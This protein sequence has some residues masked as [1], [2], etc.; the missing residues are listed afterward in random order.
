M[1]KGPKGRKRAGSR[2]PA[3]PT[4]EAS[5]G[6][7]STAVPSKAKKRERSRGPPGAEEEN[8]KLR[9]PASR[10]A[11][12]EKA[13]AEGER[14]LQEEFEDPFGDEFESEDCYEDDGEGEEEEDDVDME[15]G[16]K[17]VFRPGIDHL[18]DGEQLDVDMSSYDM[19]HRAQVDWPCLSFD[20]MPDT[21]GMNRNTYPMTCYVIAG[22]QADETENNRLY[23]MKWSQLYRTNKDDDS[24]S[25]EDSDEDEDEDAVMDFKAIP[26]PGGVN[27]VRVMP[28][29]RHLSATWSDTGKVHMWN[30]LGQC[31]GLDDPRKIPAVATPKPIFTCEKH[32]TEGFA[33]DWNPHTTG[34]FLS[35]SCD[36]T[37][38]LW[39]P[40]EGGWSVGA[41]KFSAHT[42]SVE[43]VQWKR[44]GSDAATTFASASVDRSVR[45]WDS[46]EHVRDR[47]AMHIPEAH[48][49]D[50]NVLSWNPIVGELLLTGGDGGDFKIWDT[51]NVDAGAMA[52]FHWHKRA[53]TS[54]D[55]HPTDETALAVSSEDNSVSLWDMAVEDDAQGAELPP[56]AEHFPS[57]LLFLHQ[58]QT[59]VKEV[60][61][62]PQIPSLCIS[63]AMS[64]FN[65][66]KT[67]NI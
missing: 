55:W 57:Q 49:A 54:V 22:T 20:I 18:E 51:R 3:E 12:H 62:H 43:D 44:T 58:G 40:V 28:Q 33:M 64:G 29:V 15:E 41:S 36:S 26:H 38:L 67:C 5:G 30:L 35:G 37:I 21:L 1:S 45:V 16:P 56:G 48:S 17:A 63:T 11:E 60:K 61:W 24:D 13:A 53:I 7:P 27:R 4:E 31:N 8:S 47:S 19:L 59:D 42:D 23:V 32:K 9:D 14:A 52:N 65:V 46:R 39:E 66:F 2:G 25:E 50:V 6:Y 10:T 34:Q